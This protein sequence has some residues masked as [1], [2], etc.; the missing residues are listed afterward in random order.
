MHSIKTNLTVIQ[1]IAYCQCVLLFHD[2]SANALT[3]FYLL[4]VSEGLTVYVHFE[5][6][7]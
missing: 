6:C 5:V 7:L 4:R 3:L 2:Y 1:T